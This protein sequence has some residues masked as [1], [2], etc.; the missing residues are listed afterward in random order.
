MAK[1]LVKSE[2]DECGIDDFARDPQG[3]IPWDGV[4]NYQARNFLAQMQEG[5]EVFIYHS[6]CKHIGIAGI[7][8]VAKSAYPD[9]LQFD[10]DSRYF[11]AKSSPDKPR[12]QAVDLSFVR[13]LPKLISLDR[14]KSL[15]GL[16]DLPLVRKGTR[17]SVMPVSDHDWETI[18]TL[19][20]TPNGH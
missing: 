9:P 4:R 12:W 14:I 17:L 8:R 16:T 11:D 18:L 10:P 6:S 1:W 13:K 5:D 3:V 20:A 2:P 15:Q 7:V 19:D